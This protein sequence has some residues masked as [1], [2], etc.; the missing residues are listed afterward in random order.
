METKIGEGK[1]CLLIFLFLESSLP[2]GYI[3]NQ[4][5]FSGS[6]TCLGQQTTQSTTEAYTQPQRKFLLS[7]LA[8]GSPRDSNK[9]ASI[10]R[11]VRKFRLSNS[12][13][14]SSSLISGGFPFQRPRRHQQHHDEVR[15][16]P[17]ILTAANRILAF[18]SCSAPHDARVP[19]S[20]LHST[21]RLSRILS[22]QAGVRSLC[23]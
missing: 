5:T 6:T 8:A 23:F 21:P 9:E 10:F 15:V 18:K 19:L 17:H 1:E 22:Q 11:L 16:L 12:F 4:R 14:S 13:L 2:R 20:L 3:R 7:F